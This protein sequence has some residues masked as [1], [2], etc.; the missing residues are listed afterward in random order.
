[1]RVPE[2]FE[3]IVVSETKFIQNVPLYLQLNIGEKEGWFGRKEKKLQLWTVPVRLTEVSIRMKWKVQ[4]FHDGSKIK[5]ESLDFEKTKNLGWPIWL[6]RTLKGEIEVLMEDISVESV[7]NEKFEILRF[8]LDPPTQSKSVY[9]GYNTERMFKYFGT[10]SSTK[11][12]KSIKF[13]V[14]LYWRIF[15]KGFERYD[16][17]LNAPDVVEETEVDCA[18]LLE[19]R[20]DGESFDG[21]KLVHVNNFA[22]TFSPSKEFV[23]NTINFDP[24]CLKVRATIIFHKIGQLELSKTAEEVMT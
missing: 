4:I 22:K 24:D 18:V 10:K 16:L 11:A 9:S 23:G 19:C 14:R 7:E 20:K 8:E 5:E 3:D 12:I 2:E 1:M 15:D 21:G 17:Y 6:D 13:Y